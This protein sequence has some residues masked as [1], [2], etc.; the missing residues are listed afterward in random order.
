MVWPHSYIQR[1]EN[2]PAKPPIFYQFLDG[3]GL[4]ISTPSVSESST[5]A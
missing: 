1:V 4:S 2:N 5:I 3:A